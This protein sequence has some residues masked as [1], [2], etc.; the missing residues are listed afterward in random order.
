[1]SY[2]AGYDSNGRIDMSRMFFQLLRSL[3]SRCSVF[4]GF[5]PLLLINYMRSSEVCNQAKDNGPDRIIES[6]ETTSNCGKRDQ[7]N[8]S[9][10]M[11]N[12]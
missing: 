2:A 4:M 9:E 12:T 1:M 10:L 3:G 7:L 11:D 8:I 6:F 5:S